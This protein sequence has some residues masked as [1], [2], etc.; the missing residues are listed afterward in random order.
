MG[1]L[2][3]GMPTSQIDEEVVSMISASA[4]V[5]PNDEPV[6]AR[7]RAE[8]FG[9]WLIDYFRS[10]PSHSFL[11]TTTDDVPCCPGIAS[12]I[13]RKLIYGTYGTQGPLRFPRR[14]ADDKP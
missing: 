2:Q 1:E 11:G 13:S 5:S 4:A 8:E 6:V 7:Q 12:S 10:V 9:E 3:E 14:L